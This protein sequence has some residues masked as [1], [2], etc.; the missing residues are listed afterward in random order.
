M[1]S[2]RNINPV[3]RAVGTMGAV[4]ALVGGVT[5]A[6]L[7]SNTV[8]LSPNTLSSASAA[9]AI[10]AG[11]SCPQGNTTSTTGLN[12]KLVPGQ[13]SAPFGF[14][15]D[16]TGDIPLHITA[17]IPTNFSVSAIAPTDITLT[18]TCPTIGTLSGTL[19]Q[20]SSPAA[21][22]GPAL[23]QNTPEDCTATATLS[24]A[25]SGSGSQSA[26]PFDIVF[27]GNE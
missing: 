18:L 27:V 12:T 24:A 7:Q 10:G 15:L 9:L 1:I 22:P 11:T 6:N 23:V 19:D 8:A 17:Q 13:T 3:V 26:T 2:L 16:N 4:A 14:C 20:Y 5:F 25:Y 21:F